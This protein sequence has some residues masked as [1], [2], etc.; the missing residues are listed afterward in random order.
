M[1]AIYQQDI[2]LRDE[3]IVIFNVGGK[4]SI[5]FL[6]QGVLHKRNTR[7]ATQRHFLDLASRQG[8]MTQTRRSYDFCNKIQKIN[9]FHCVF[10][11]T[12]HSCTAKFG[13]LFRG[14]KQAQML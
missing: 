14:L 8:G 11:L 4:I 1:P 7:T 12:N 3:E 5:H 6:T 13:F 10:K 2:A 9:F